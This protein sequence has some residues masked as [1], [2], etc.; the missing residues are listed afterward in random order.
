LSAALLLRSADSAEDADP[1]LQRLL[2]VM[3]A[4]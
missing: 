2:S 1:P 4:P 3:G